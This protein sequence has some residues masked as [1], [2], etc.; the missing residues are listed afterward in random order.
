MRRI[1]LVHRGT[2]NAIG[3]V[4]DVP[5]IGEAAARAR[6]ITHLGSGGQ[7][8]DLPD[9]RWLLLAAQRAA[10][11]A[12]SAPGGV[13]VELAEDAGA[14]P[15]IAPERLL[16]E[17]RHGQACSLRADDLP[18]VDRSEWFDLGEVT[19]LSPI[20]V[21]SVRPPA[22]PAAAPTVDLRKA[23]RVKD[24]SA[25]TQATVRRLVAL[26]ESRKRRRP[27]PATASGGVARPPRPP[28]LRNAIFKRLMRTP[29]AKTIG[30]KHAK[31][32]E[33]LARR[34]ESGD[35]EEALHRAI[36]LGGDASGPDGLL[37]LRLPRRRSQLKITPAGNAPGRSVPYGPTIQQ[38]LNATYRAAAK[39]LE[40]RGEIDQA[41]YVLVELLNDAG[42]GVAMLE[43]HERFET[44]ATIAEQRRL[45]GFTIVRLW[46]LAKRRD[47]AIAL[48]RRHRAFAIAIDRLEPTDR[49]AALQ[50]RLEWANDLERG[51]DLLG[52]VEAAWPRAELRPA[53]TNLID[54]GARLGG[55]T[56]GALRAYAVALDATTARVESAI[57]LVRTGD[58][59]EVRSFLR[60]F[61]NMPASDPV[62][63]R[64]IASEFIRTTPRELERVAGTTEVWWAVRSRADTA[65][66]ADLPRRGKPPTERTAVQVPRLAPGQIEVRDAAGLSSGDV[67]VALGPM[68]CRLIRPDSSVAAEWRSPTSTIVMAD[69]GGS[70][71]LLD[72]RESSQRS[73][74]EF[75]VRRLDLSTRRLTFYGTLILHSF[76]DS[77]DGLQ[78][79]VI[80]ERN[81]AMM[82]LTAAVPTIGW[83]PVESESTCRSIHRTSN[84]VTALVVSGDGRLAPRASELR[85]WDAPMNRLMKKK[86]I[87]FAD[88]VTGYR[89]L[90][91]ELMTFTE[92]SV[93]V[94][95]INARTT[96]ALAPG[97]GIIVADNLIGHHV[98]SEIG[99]SLRVE[100]WPGQQHV[101]TLELEAGERSPRLRSNAGLATVWDPAGR[102]HVIDVERLELLSSIRTLV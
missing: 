101:L 91:M 40:R 74:T 93:E 87:Q 30:R 51:G 14:A 81:A 12:E 43:R 7:L 67:L 34:F 97:E 84:Q 8:L 92:S 10:V 33:D 42:G 60:V 15:G 58:N 59:P 29:A 55:T 11:R 35:M 64:R 77:F 79:L 2:A 71:L 25:A 63:D 37:S 46:W 57:D 52:A 53:L 48:A 70:A 18:P 41:L 23:A 66:V 73:G 88:D 94:T 27:V 22:D 78:W 31:Y 83:R 100:R 82:D 6:A 90:P 95:N 68:G 39:E 26:S 76:A 1:D 3:F 28:K 69:H 96:M 36:P 47:R 65:L 21:T 5:T 24:A 44:A 61:A 56:G 9:G 4:I 45:D 89:L 102:A 99:Q 50:L 19:V 80:D 20:H 16:R 17:Q 38:R 98:S 72:G 62:V 32:I 49:A 85:G 86:V 75:D 13:L 54:R